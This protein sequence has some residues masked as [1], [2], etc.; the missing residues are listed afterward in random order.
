MTEL[1]LAQYTW[2]AKGQSEIVVEQRNLSNALP[3]GLNT[4]ILVFPSSI[5]KCSNLLREN[6]QALMEGPRHFGQ[7]YS[8]INSKNWHVPLRTSQCRGNVVC[9]WKRC[10]VLQLEAEIPAA[11]QLFKERLSRCR[12]ILGTFWATSSVQIWS[13]KITGSRSPQY[14]F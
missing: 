3:R 7:D 9:V 11:C 10:D 1:I 2:K 4:K 5:I 8:S 12:D 14:Q 6:W 13:W